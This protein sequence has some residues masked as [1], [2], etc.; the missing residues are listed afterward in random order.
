[1]KTDNAKTNFEIE[2]RNKICILTKPGTKLRQK[3]SDN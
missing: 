3:E 2:Q 1:M